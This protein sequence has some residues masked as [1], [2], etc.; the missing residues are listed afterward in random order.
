MGKFSTG[1]T[2]VGRSLT[3]YLTLPLGVAAIGA[4]KL[5]T[6]FQTSMTHIR[7]L[8]GASKSQIADW[9]K[10]ILAMA[11]ALGKAPK[12]LADAL[13]FITSSGFKGAAALK[14]LRASA[15][16][17]TAG[18]GD[19]QVV[20]DAVTSA[21]NAYG[22]KV[23]SAAQA[24][25]IMIATVRDGKAEPTQLAQSLGR[26]ISPAAVLGVTFRDVG[27]SIAA[28]TLKGMDSFTATTALRQIFVTMLK[29]A[30]GTE[31]ALKKVGLSAAGLRQELKQKGLLAT[32][33]TLA[34]KVKGNS[35]LA[36]KFFPNVR[37]LNGFLASMGANAKQTSH[38][39][40]DLH[41]TT[42]LTNKAF[43][44]ASQSAGVKFHQA[45][46]AIKVVGIEVGNQILPYFVRF[47]GWVAKLAVRFSQLSPHTKHLVIELAAM[48]AAIGPT[49]FALGKLGQAFTA[50][51]KHPILTALS[52]LVL[53][54]IH[55]YTHSQRFHDAVNRV[56]SALA[57]G[58][59]WINKHK[60]ALAALTAGFVAF[61]TVL[62]AQAVL[63]SLIGAVRTFGGV[64]MGL[65]AV[66][67]N[68]RVAMFL[69][70]AAFL[71]NP[72]GIIVA[73]CV[74]LG[75]AFVI[76]WKK[77]ETFRDVVKGVWSALKK[78]SGDFVGFM[79]KEVVKR[80]VDLW[81]TMASTI[82]GAAGKMFGWIPG[83]GGKLKKAVKAFD[84]FKTNVD[85]TL[86]GLAD[87]AYGYG[88]GIGAAVAQGIG[89]GID[90]HAY[91]AKTAMKLLVARTVKEG[92][93]A[94]N[95]NSPSRLT[96]DQIG[97]PLA[98]GVGVGISD[99][100]AGVMRTIDAQTKKLMARWKKA[101]ERLTEAQ[102]HLSTVMAGHDSGT[103][104]NRH[105]V[106]PT[107]LAL[108]AAE[109][110]VKHAKETAQKAAK[111]YQ[112]SFQAWLNT[113]ARR[114]A[115]K[116]LLGLARLLAQGLSG[117]LGFGAG[118]I[119]TAATK[120]S[121]AIKK[122]FADPSGKVPTAVADAMKKLKSL[123]A[124]AGE[125]RTG[126]IENLNGS[127]DLTQAL[128]GN[129]GI[130]AGDVKAFL[131]RQL[132]RVK[133]FARDIKILVRKGVPADFIRQIANGGLDGGLPIADALV[134][135][136]SADF[137]EVLSLQK[138]LAA[139]SNSAGNL[140]QS[141]VFAGGLTGKSV[142][143]HVGSRHDRCWRN[144]HQP[145]RTHR[146]ERKRHRRRDRLGAA[147]GQGQAAPQ[148]EEASGAQVTALGLLDWQVSVGGVVLG[149]G[150]AYLIHD[151]TGLGASDVRSSDVERPQDDGD[152][153]GTDLRASRNVELP[154]TVTG[155]TAS[156]AY[157][158]VQTLLKAW[159]TRSTENTRPLNFKLPGQPE[160]ILD[161]RPRRAPADTLASLKSRIVPMT[162]E[163][164][165]ATAPVLSATQKSATALAPT[166]AGGRAY[167]RVYPMTYGGTGAA[168]SVTVTNAGTYRTRPVITITGPAVNPSIQNV[169]QGK[170]LSFAISVASGDTLV[171]D[172]DARSVLLN[173]T[174]SRRSALVAGSQW[175]DLDPG[176]SQ[177]TYAASSGTGGYATVAFNDAYL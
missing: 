107:A 82:L 27:A 103:G 147:H 18:L 88:E 114:K 25:D 43:R 55:A 173:G 164:Y 66:I 15:K 160:M 81:L 69:L 113:N 132:G 119:E 134:N 155:T 127:N 97:K 11:P 130:G 131:S 123:A 94:A 100:M 141:A 91:G 78:A 35:A 133:R 34:D 121:N 53:L 6:D 49:I 14:V 26:V 48:A 80:I 148:E 128:G 40:G 157:A 143:G 52:V 67:L 37:A 95:V 57:A 101:Q 153:Y 42:G 117:S 70:D 31:D 99:G 115:G 162:L 118:P 161:G 120:L 38:I 68:V 12:E 146:R 86:S 62:K 122:Q 61:F 73:A 4:V 47:A 125:F 7:A 59:K 105:H 98:E 108:Q 77:S 24:T 177:I 74:A 75:V 175:W 13:Y 176:A 163:Y 156:D 54:F 76:L 159:W 92:R 168:N 39:F 172:T 136:S 140:A 167:P 124:K 116:P 17:S 110:T 152:F 144:R 33:Q 106:G 87:S 20:A 28:M 71:A 149:P 154:I 145:Q 102:K 56:A 85:A 150:T 111:A 96:R 170:T 135:A 36:A 137:A 90:K 171:I 60:V 5:A 64:M 139:A 151:Y 32:L 65:R 45:L 63:T 1:M 22:H 3:Q 79:I 10:Q 165:S 29:P 41:H 174:A 46:S 169:T 9:S 84:N 51:A 50:V 58:V 109:N 44:E 166:A 89:L 112:Q 16:A 129:G 23:L 83:I 142:N 93:L 19:T 72:I 138:Q 30:K 2:R 8:V 126:F 21:M 158:N 104:K